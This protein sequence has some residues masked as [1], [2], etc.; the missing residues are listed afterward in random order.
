VNICCY[1]LVAIH[2]FGESVGIPWVLFS[3]HALFIAA[4]TYTSN[5]INFMAV[6]A[7]IALG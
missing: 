3:T 2:F 7:S 1:Q 4:C 6:A 5:D